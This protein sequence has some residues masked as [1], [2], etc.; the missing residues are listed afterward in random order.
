MICPRQNSLAL[1]DQSFHAP[2]NIMD[3]PL[4]CSLRKIELND[5]HGGC[6]ELREEANDG[7]WTGTLVTL[8]GWNAADTLG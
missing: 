7:V 1:K 3:L 2:Q 8:F 5:F 4:L 6:Y